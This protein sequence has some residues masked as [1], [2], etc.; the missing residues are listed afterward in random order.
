MAATKLQRLHTSTEGGFPK[1]T[2]I[3][4]PVVDLKKI[5]GTPFYFDKEG[6]VYLDPQVMR[7]LNG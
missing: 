5:P 7:T 3:E 1:S 2:P 4:V 6:R